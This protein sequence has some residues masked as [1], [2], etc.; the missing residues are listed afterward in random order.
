VR[1]VATAEV[2]S[3]T[4]TSNIAREGGAVYLDCNRGDLCDEPPNE[5]A[6]ADCDI[7]SNHAA[8]EVWRLW[9]WPLEI[10]ISRFIPSVSSR[11]ALTLPACRE[12]HYTWD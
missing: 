1:G 8:N 2:T 3:C 5:L 12:A 7:I 10:C 6:V 4:M 11:N 9:L